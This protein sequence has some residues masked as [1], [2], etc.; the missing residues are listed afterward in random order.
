MAA[1][2][3]RVQASRRPI[4]ARARPSATTAYADA[5]A[6]PPAGPSPVLSSRSTTQGWSPRAR[7]P[8]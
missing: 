6:R 5:T 1:R 3:L 2:R 8:V 4:T 7:E